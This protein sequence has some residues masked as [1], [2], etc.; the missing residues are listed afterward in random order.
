MV[1]HEFANKIRELFG[2]QEKWLDKRKERLGNIRLEVEEYERQTLQLLSLM[3]KCCTKD[4]LVEMYCCWAGEYD[5]PAE[6]QIEKP[7]DMEVLTK[8]FEV[9][10]KQFVTFKK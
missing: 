8:D 1:G 7:F 3:D 6:E 2:V 9:E 5:D 4:G 10:L